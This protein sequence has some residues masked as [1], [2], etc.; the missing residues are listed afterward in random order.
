VA[1]V[2]DELPRWEMESV[3]GPEPDA[4]DRAYANAIAGID[5]LAAL[6]D[7]LGVAPR[8][9]GS[10]DADTVAAVTEVLAAVDRVG[11]EAAIQF[12]YLFCAV[13]AD[14]GNDAAQA[15]LGELQQANV[16]LSQLRT[17]IVAWIGSLD[18]EA[19]IAA[20]PVAQ[21][22]AYILRDAA[23]RAEHLMSRAEEELAAELA[24]SGAAAWFRLRQDVEAA[25]MATIEV[26][27]EVQTI[28]LAELDRFFSSPNRE[29]RRRAYDANRETL[30]GARTPFAA[31]LNGVKGE[32]IALLRRR[33][34][35]DPLDAALHLNRIDR[36]TLDAMMG[37]IRAAVPDLRRFLRAKARPLGIPVLA[38]YD[39][40]A[41]VSE[42]GDV[43]PYGESVRFVTEQFATYSPRL[44]ALAERATGERWI[45]AGP[46]EGK[47]GGGFC[48]GVGNGVSRILLNYTPN[49][50][51]M[52]AVAHELGHAYHDQAAHTAGRSWLQ[53]SLTPAT[54]AETASTFCET[55]VQ[56]QVLAQANE[57]SR[58]E[59]LNGVIQ[60]QMINVFLTGIGFDTERAIFAQRPERQ[61]SAEELTEISLVAQRDLFGD[62]IDQETL[63]S[64]HWASLPHY[65]LP[66]FWYYNFPYA[67][68]MLFGL[69]L[70]ARYREE[71]AGFPGRFDALL[72]DT[73]M[74]DAVDL[75]ARFGI[76]LHSTA[77]WEAGLG[78]FRTRV[79]QF[80]A[81]VDRQL[82]I[83]DRP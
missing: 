28:P 21:H 49:F 2:V 17:R 69:G 54:L 62:A 33:N 40:F 41:P 55:L 67:F 81:L 73:G 24:P 46:R 80:E 7:W 66:D 37:A 75:A 48:A 63:W 19:L 51:W 83:P 26:D 10:V 32:Q 44:A 36:P 78:T 11:Q 39:L 60:G 65:F 74:A 47:T 82:T 9:H 30:Q 61:L 72:A 14:S 34:W 56:E 35:D 29:T 3:F 6:L 79:D 16:C 23:V 38:T 4:A 52:S 53:Q 58:L 15:R 12:S 77:F 76:D 25:L 18:T 59:L 5:E 27:G 8:D 68:G 20:S 22:H 71:P 57:L 43:W 42:A 45:D 70:Y 1:S 31:A 64:Y 50:I 13:S